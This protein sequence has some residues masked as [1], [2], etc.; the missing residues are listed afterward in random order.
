MSERRNLTVQQRV[1]SPR[2]LS[3]SS[4]PSGTWSSLAR[5][6]QMLS[7]AEL[8]HRPERSAWHCWPVV[9]SGVWFP[10]ALTAVDVSCGVLSPSTR[11]LPP[12]RLL[13][14][15]ASLEQEIHDC[16]LYGE[17]GSLG[18]FCQSCLLTNL[19]DAG[20]GLCSVPSTLPSGPMAKMPFCPLH[21]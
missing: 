1:S 3:H 9:S 10:A 11:F 17:S 4:R 16:V 14:K 7:T 18:V 5:A 6:L 19:C 12:R 8:W 21:G 20:G 2:A 13:L 15:E